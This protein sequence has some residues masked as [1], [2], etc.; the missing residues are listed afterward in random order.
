MNLLDLPNEILYNIKT[1]ELNFV[2]KIII[3]PDIY[4]DYLI[5]ENNNLTQ[6]KAIKLRE[7]INKVLQPN[8]DYQKGCI[9]SGQY[10]D[11]G[12]SQWPISDT[13]II[14][15]VLFYTLILFQ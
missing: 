15:F 12:P 7:N 6:S 4:N 5:I 2:A 11:H 8:I 9:W 14:N 1:Y 3:D 13:N 10:W